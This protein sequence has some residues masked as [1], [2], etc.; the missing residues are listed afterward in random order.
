MS[1]ERRRR[2]M[3]VYAM[4]SSGLSLFGLDLVFHRVGE[5]TFGG[6]VLMLLGLLLYGSA[7][8]LAALGSP[9]VSLFGLAGFFVGMFMASELL[10]RVFNL[11]TTVLLT[12]M[13][14]IASVGFWTGWIVL[15]AH[16]AEPEL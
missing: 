8:L 4:S 7:G 11:T 2:V 6:L 1:M 12:L 9:R 3:L 14:G 15:R 10:S 16:D 5:I 13:Y